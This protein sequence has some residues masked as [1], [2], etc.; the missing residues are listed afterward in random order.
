MDDVLAKPH[1]LRSFDLEDMRQRI[2]SM[3]RQIAELRVNSRSLYQMARKMSENA[4]L[5][6]RYC[7][8]MAKLFVD[9][10]S[11]PLAFVIAPPEEKR[12]FDYSELCETE[13]DPE[14]API[15]EHRGLPPRVNVI[16]RKVCEQFDVTPAELFGKSKASK[17]ATARQAAMSFL[18]L[19]NMG[20]TAIGRVFDRDH[21]TVLHAVEKHTERMQ[22]DKVY[23]TKIMKI[24]ADMMP[25]KE[26]A[27]RHPLPEGA[28][29][30]CRSC[31]H[32]FPCQFLE[33]LDCPQCEENG[34]SLTQ[35]MTEIAR[36][37]RT[38][39]A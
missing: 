33:D 24:A 19:C 17:Y 25:G 6:E 34:R 35:S 9:M 16:V 27:T 30:R 11:Q 7:D 10:D 2:R 22:E 37:M 39:V 18:N 20:P 26:A 8:D 5:I 31:G 3:R 29:R 12:R 4:D 32:V 13:D 1:M 28:M 36:S 38:S 23:R 21:T 14:A 15:P